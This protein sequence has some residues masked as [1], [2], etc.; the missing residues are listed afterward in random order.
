MKTKILKILSYIGYTLSVLHVLFWAINMG[1]LSIAL[2]LGFFREH[3][4]RES[5]LYNGTLSTATVHAINY[6]VTY[7]YFISLVLLFGDLIV[8]LVRRKPKV[9]TDEPQRYYLVTGL[10]SVIIIM[11][12]V[13]VYIV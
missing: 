4:T 1:G 11:Y 12:Q 3:E 2:K 9:Q 8:G 5:P 10:L 7:V 6:M 13:G